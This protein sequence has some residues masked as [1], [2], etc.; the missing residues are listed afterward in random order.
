MITEAAVVAAA[1]AAAATGL[2]RV[3][4]NA[5]HKDIGRDDDDDDDQDDQM[6][7]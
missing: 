4:G 1:I 6:W 7:Y 2:G 3:G 5:P